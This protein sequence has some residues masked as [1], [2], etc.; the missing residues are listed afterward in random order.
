MILTVLDMK[1]GY[2]NWSNESFQK[3]FIEADWLYFRKKKITKTSLF[4]MIVLIDPVLISYPFAL[5]DHF[6]KGS[7]DFIERNNVRQ[8]FSN[9]F[10]S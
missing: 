5:S 9:I 6:I 2:L 1:E 3:Y 8:N 10:E 4:F 7:A